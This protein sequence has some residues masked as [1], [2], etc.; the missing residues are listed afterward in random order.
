MPEEVPLRF[1]ATLVALS[2]F[3][4][5][6]HAQTLSGR[7]FRTEAAETLDWGEHAIEIGV[8]YMSEMTPLP[9][10]DGSARGDYWR[11]PVLRYRA[12]LGRA[13]FHVAGALLTGFSP[14][15]PGLDSEEEIGDFALWLKV[16]ALKEAAGRPGLGFL[17]G[18]KMP[19]ASDE[20]G[21]GTDESDVFLG[22]VLSKHVG[23]HEMR[24][25]LGLAILGDP[26]TNAAQQ[27][28]LTYGLAGRHG[29]RHALLWEV[30]G[31]AF[32]DEER[33]LEEST[34]RLGYGLF[35]DSVSFDASLLV[36][37][38]ENSGDLGASLGVT[39][40]LGSPRQP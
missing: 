8:D 23:I 5:A 20:T 38:E 40:L 32:G 7:P 13:E 18:T 27:D 24:L 31:R 22:L 35:G 14:D 39:W 16:Q 2:L 37:L 30:W 12:G 33:G 4:T 21:L 15:A 11:A 25:N 29:D 17:V 9:I 3:A 34:L 36:G 6:L 10:L 19:N 26:L 28:L 1:A